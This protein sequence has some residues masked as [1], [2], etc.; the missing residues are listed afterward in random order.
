MFYLLI[1]LLSFICITD[2][3]NRKIHNVS[4][5]GTLIIALLLSPNSWMSI[6]PSMLVCFVIG[7]CLF[8][9]QV[10]GGGDSKLIVSLSPLFTV[11]QLPDFFVTMLLCGGM[12]SVI[13]WIKYRLI[14]QKSPDRGLPYGVA[15]VCGAII[16]LYFSQGL[17]IY[18]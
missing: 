2:V 18:S 7:F 10:W 4:A 14:P 6:Y 11:V 5:G 9:M 16:S 15:I 8:A 3:F 17:A 13:Y 12:L 1:A